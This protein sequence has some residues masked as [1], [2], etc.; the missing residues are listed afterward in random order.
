MSTLTVN[1]LIVGETSFNATFNAPCVVG[2]YARDHMLVSAF[3]DLLAGIN[4]TNQSIM[5]NDQDVFNNA[6][7]FKERFYGNFEKPCP[8]TLRAAYLKS[9][10][11]T[12]WQLSFNEGE[13][14]KIVKELNIRSELTIDCRYRFSKAGNTLTNYALIRSLEKPFIIIDNPTIA[15]N[16]FEQIEPVV[17]G[18]TDKNH[19]EFVFLGIDNLKVFADK[20]DYLILIGDEQT[21]MVNPKQDKLIAVSGEADLKDVIFR[22]K[23]NITKDVYDKNELKIWDKQKREYKRISP[24]DIEVFR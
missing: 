19:Y 8:S 9:Q 5:Y 17:L 11:Q 13:F 12:N 3:L 10:L 2:V 7:Y 24:F 23:I 22:S 16:S 14:S 20:L 6:T 1:N 18:L 15:L 4:Q 21:V